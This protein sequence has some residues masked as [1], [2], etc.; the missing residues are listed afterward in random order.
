[1][2]AIHHN[3]ASLDMDKLMGLEVAEAHG[4]RFWGEVINWPHIVGHVSIVGRY[5]PLSRR[6][7]ALSIGRLEAV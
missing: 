5:I 1:M 2:L 6:Q 7:E 3:N 4:V